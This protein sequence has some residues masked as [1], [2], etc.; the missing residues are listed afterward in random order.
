[1]TTIYEARIFNGKLNPSILDRIRDAI[2]AFQGKTLVITVKVYKS[3]RSLKQNAYYW[4]VVVP[5]V[6]EFFREHGNYVDNNDVHEFLKLRVGKIA[7]NIVIDGEVFRSLGSTAKLTT[8][9]F[10]DYQ[11]RIRAWAAGYGV[12]IPL[13]NETINIEGE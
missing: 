11:E 6:T 2:A 8:T 12:M 7:Q 3:K 1:M 9:E 4:S 13:P 10:E 5:A